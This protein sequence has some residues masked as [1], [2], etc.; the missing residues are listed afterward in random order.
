MER[1]GIKGMRKREEKT[2]G[3]WNGE[4][5]AKARGGVRYVKRRIG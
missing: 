4:R 3:K 1:G 2:K 5:K